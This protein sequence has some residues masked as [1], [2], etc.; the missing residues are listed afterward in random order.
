MCAAVCLG[1]AVGVACRLAIAC[2][3][4]MFVCVSSRGSPSWAVSEQ[5]Q[6]RDEGVGGGRVPLTCIRGP[7]QTKKKSLVLGLANAY[8]FEDH[9]DT[10]DDGKYWK[11]Q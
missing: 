5:R 6:R 10:D 11:G 7:S 3:I 1:V 9:G 8:V 2:E 4:V